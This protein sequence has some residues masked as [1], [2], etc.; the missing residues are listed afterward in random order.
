L[1]IGPDVT[2][3]AFIQAMVGGFLIGGAVGAVVPAA[4]RID[5]RALLQRTARPVIARSAPAP[6]PATPHSEASVSQRAFG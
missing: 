6:A 2:I 4:F 5:E 1:W 3:G